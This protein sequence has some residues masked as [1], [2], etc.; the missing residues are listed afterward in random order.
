[1]SVDHEHYFDTYYMYIMCYR[2]LY[3]YSVAIPVFGQYFE[4][5][6]ICNILYADLP[7]RNR[8]SYMINDTYFI[9]NV[10]VV[11]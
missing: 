5:V 7:T 10:L 1:M 9:R 3:F 8:M 11:P 4:S 6:W 2:R